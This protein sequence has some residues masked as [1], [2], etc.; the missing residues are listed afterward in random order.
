MEFQAGDNVIHAVYGLGKVLEREE[1]LTSDGSPI[2][3]VVQIRDMTIWVP[4]D[5]S[6]EKRL[7]VPTPFTRFE[8][9]VNTL[10]GA[11]ETLP[12]D[13]HQRKLLLIE[14]LK[15]GDVE[16]LFRAIRGLSSFGRIRPLNDGDQVLFKRLET[17]LTSEWSFIMSIPPASATHEMHRLLASAPD[18]VREAQVDSVKGKRSARGA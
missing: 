1:R 18:G 8:S 10:S 11:G 14:W 4:A 9:L 6:L 16:S 7:R 13:R 5:E 15:D 12:D 2:Y 3:Y 17:S